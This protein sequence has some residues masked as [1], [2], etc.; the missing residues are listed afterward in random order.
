MPNMFTQMD[1]VC[2]RIEELSILL[3]Q[4]YTAE[5]PAIFRMLI[6]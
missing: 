1:A 4:P 2:H 3:N 6:R 5:D